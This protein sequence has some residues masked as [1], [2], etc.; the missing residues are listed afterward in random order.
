MATA[1]N[2]YYG[3]RFYDPNLQRWLNRDRLGEE[4]DI[5]LYA[6]VFGD[7]ENWIDDDGMKPLPC[8]TIGEYIKKN[9]KCDDVDDNVIKCMAFRESSFDPGATT[10]IAGNTAAGLLGITDGAMLDAGFPPDSN[11]LDPALNIQIGS[12]Y[13]CALLKKNKGN[14]TRA[15]DKYGT[16]S[17]YGDAIR[18]CA[19]CLRSN[20][21]G[22]PAKKGGPGTND[23]CDKNCLQKAKGK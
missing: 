3:Y 2:Y 22:P 21:S 7:P 19:K 23:P 6:F 17:G 4:G 15:L 5:N 1:A 13:L 10:G 8:P 11:K 20:K 12:K 16:G 18:D 9:K 14:L